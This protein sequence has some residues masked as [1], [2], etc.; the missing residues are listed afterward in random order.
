MCD[1]LPRLLAEIRIPE[2]SYAPKFK[3]ATAGID[4][5]ALGAATLPM[6][7]LFAAQPGVLIKNNQQLSS[8]EDMTPLFSG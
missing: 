4:A 5:A 1:D 7:N 2:K 8:F 6:F 3:C